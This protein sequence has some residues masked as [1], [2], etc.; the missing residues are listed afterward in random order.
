MKY[1]NAVRSICG[2]FLTTM[3]RNAFGVVLL[4]I[5]ALLP[6][7]FSLGRAFTTDEAHQWVAYRSASFLT[8]VAEGRFADTIIT[9]HPGVTTMWLGSLGL[10]LED[11]LQAMGALTVPPSFEMHLTLMRLPLACATALCVPLAYLLLRRIIDDGIALLA[12]LLWATDPFLVAHSRV[13]HLDALLSL[14]L[15]LAVLALL[16]ACFDRT[17]VRAQPHR[18]TIISAGIATGLALLTKSPAVFVLPIGGLVLLL[19]FWHA[20]APLSLRL[21]MFI[22][23]GLLW[24]CTAALT[25]LLLW[26]ALWVAPWQAIVSV[27]SEAVGNSTE[28]HKGNFL[29]GQSYLFD[30]PGPLYY[31]V[32]LLSRLTPWVVLGLAAA[33]LSPSLRRSPRRV[34][35]LLV[36]CA[37]VLF[38]AILSLLSKKLDRYAL[39]A[40]PLLHILAAVGLSWL[41]EQVG[42]WW[43]RGRESR[44]RIVRAVGIIGVGL[45]AAASLAWYHPYY[46]A[47]YSPL[48][49]LL[50]PFTPGEDI[51][52][53]VLIGWGEGLDLVADWLN[54]RPDIDAGEVSTWSAP[55]LQ[56]YLS[57]PTT[58]Q[59]A[60]NSRDRINYLVVYVNQ[61][62][63]GR[64]GHFIGDIHGH[65]PPVHTVRLHGIDYAWVYER[66]M[67]HVI[68]PP[69]AQFGQAFILDDYVLEAPD[70]CTCEPLSLTLALDPLTQPEQPLFFF[71]HVLDAQGQ[72][73]TQFDIPLNDLI[74]SEYWQ[75]DETLFHPL[76]IPLPPAAPPGEYQIILGLYNPATGTRQPIVKN[77]ADTGAA[78]PRE[79][80]P[81]VTF[82]L[83]ETF[84]S[85][86]AN[87]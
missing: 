37:A 84:Q 75:R 42:A 2:P 60:L 87:P 58:W 24:F 28:P 26:P 16:S 5:A 46:L 53:V 19:W 49:H 74:F 56:A 45:V 14:L 20:A 13:L 1:L 10:L 33:I 85:H 51:A 7:I 4:I 55:T 47:Y 86:C 57:A 35:L 43:V 29:L 81:I 21:R 11:A 17:G 23:S 32:T 83:T 59:G 36:A 25:V 31:P 67:V 12:A 34:P 22:T 54:E 64:E 77:P 30:A 50:R 61:T 76:T 71:V 38:V 73:V 82:Q 52:D 18:P 70:S 27:T 8:A 39:P 68:E 63:T 48:T 6:R 41:F 72:A 66:P 62:Q 69:G 80:L 79:Q 9:G 78:R 15:L 44:T 65:C 3:H 40:V